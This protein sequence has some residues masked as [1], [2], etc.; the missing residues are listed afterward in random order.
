MRG[1]GPA[2]MLLGRDAAMSGH[3]VRD[4]LGRVRAQ[5]RERRLRRGTQSARGTDAHNATI[6]AVRAVLMQSSC[7]HW[8]DEDGCDA[9]A[10]VRLDRKSEAHDLCPAM[11]DAYYLHGSDEEGD[12]CTP[13]A[14]TDVWLEH[15]AEHWAQPWA[16]PLR[17]WALACATAAENELRPATASPG[18][19]SLELMPSTADLQPL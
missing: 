9:Y 8:R 6:A 7:Y 10:I 1:L 17:L 13:W 15:H 14:C 11:Y 16:L 18:P 3:G 4:L 5:E 12:P 2:I 19:E